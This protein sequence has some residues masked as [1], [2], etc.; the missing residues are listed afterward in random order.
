MLGPDQIT[1]VPTARLT[2][3]VY[4]EMVAH[5]LEERPFEGCGLLAGTAGQATTIYRCQN[6]AELNGVRYEISGRDILRIT[7]EIDDEDLE[8]LAIYHSHPYTRAYP[9]AKDVSI[10]GWPVFY[11][12]VSLVDFRHPVVKAYTIEAGVVTEVPIEV[13]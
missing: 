11:I 5:A 9:S 12:L 7:R 6:A 3:A 10:A 2:R 4:D 13:V 8:L 1:S